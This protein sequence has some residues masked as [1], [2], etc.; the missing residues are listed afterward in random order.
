MLKL[1]V[2]LLNWQ[3]DIIG[4]QSAFGLK[5]QNLHALCHW[6]WSYYTRFF[7]CLLA[8]NLPL[9]FVDLLPLVEKTDNL[10]FLC[11]LLCF[12]PW[13]GNKN[14][15]I[16]SFTNAARKRHEHSNGVSIL[17]GCLLIWLFDSQ[18]SLVYFSGLKYILARKMCHNA[19][20]IDNNRFLYTRSAVL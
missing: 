8:Q 9:T 20:Q 18:F 5:L 14:G 1:I 7:W 15:A 17:I 11:C 6:P 10:D 3:F 19:Q 12:Q 16:I 2:R 13:F 4:E